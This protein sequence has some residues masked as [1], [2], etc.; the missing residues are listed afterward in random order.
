MF[1]KSEG[2]LKKARDDYCLRVT[3]ACTLENLN[4]GA[5]ETLFTEYLKLKEQFDDSGSSL[6]SWAQWFS[7]PFPITS[8]GM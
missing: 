2:D 1:T 7:L 8:S 4:F 6:G 3:A 5:V